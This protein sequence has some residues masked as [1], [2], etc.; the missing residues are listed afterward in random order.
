MVLSK[1]PGI[2]FIV[3]TDK[4]TVGTTLNKLA[5]AKQIFKNFNSFTVIVL[6]DFVIIGSRISKC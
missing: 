3:Y 5:K 4:T 1:N 2:H 6:V